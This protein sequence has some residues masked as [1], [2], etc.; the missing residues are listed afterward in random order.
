MAPVPGN[1]RPDRADTGG[2]VLWWYFD[3]EAAMRAAK[4]SQVVA[5][6]YGG[7]WVAWTEDHTRIV[8]AADTFEEVRTAAERVGL[9]D[10]IFLWV[11]PSDE[12]FI[13]GSE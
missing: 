8:A 3:Q 4:M 10:P 7:K 2:T 1:D 12:P 5:R 11:P 9:R 13:G 6:E